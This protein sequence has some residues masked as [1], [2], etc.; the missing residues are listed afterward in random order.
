MI[1]DFIN[2]LVN[3]KGYSPH[4]AKSYERDLKDFARW[5][6]TER[7]D[8]RWSTITMADLDKYITY[9]SKNG[10][11]PSTTNRRLSSISGLFTYFKHKGLKIDN[12]TKFESR[13]KVADTIPNTIPVED[14]KKAYD[15]AFGIAKQALGILMSTGIRVQEL[16][17][18]T[19]DDIDFEKNSIRI[20]GKG[21]KDR[22]VY[23][24]ADKLE[25]LRLVYNSQPQPGRVFSCKQRKMRSIIHDAIKP[26]SNAPQ[27]SPH[28]IR[29]TFATNAAN[30]GANVSTLATA[31]GHKQLVTTQKY[32]D[33][34]GAPVAQ[35]MTTYNM[36]N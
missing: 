26:Y 11:K 3:I 35:L 32:I 2:Y 34:M 27:L 22:M 4:T 12:P 20:H 23:T 14:L 10:K 15:N 5:I 16:L 9:L 8:A 1:Q 29:H 7:P 24:T 28:A 17:D 30:R 31:L 33:M 36:F 18:I 13:R 25:T 21:A 6:K 19:W